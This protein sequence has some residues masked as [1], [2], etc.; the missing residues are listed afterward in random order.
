MTELL[1]SNTATIIGRA[2]SE[3]LVEDLRKR[4]ESALQVEASGVFH[5]LSLSRVLKI[6]FLAPVLLI[7]HFF[8]VLIG[9]FFLF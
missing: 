7:L 5:I 4:L 6:R 8:G 2:L 3:D 9:F 1:I